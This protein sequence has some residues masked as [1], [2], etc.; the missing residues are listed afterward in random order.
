VVIESTQTLSHAFVSIF[1]EVLRIERFALLNLTGFVRIWKKYEVVEGGAFTDAG[2]DLLRADSPARGDRGLLADMHATE[3]AQ[4]RGLTSL[5]QETEQAY[6]EFFCGGNTRVAKADLHAVTKGTNDYADFYKGIKFGAMLLLALWVLWDVVVDAALRPHDSLHWRQ[7]VFPVYRAVFC[8]LFGAWCWGLNCYVWHAN[9]INY[10]YLFRLN[11]GSAVTYRDVFDHCTHWTLFVLTTFLLYYKTERG[12]LPGWVPA[13]VWP[14]VTFIPVFLR[15]LWFLRSHSRGHTNGWRLGLLQ[16][17]G[18]PFTEVTFL[19]GYIG[20]VLTSLVKV[21]ADIYYSLCWLGGGWWLSNQD[22]TPNP[23]E[24]VEVCLESSL[25]VNFIAPLLAALPLW[26]RLMQ[27]LRTYYDVRKR[28]PSLANAGK[29][30]TGMSVVIFGIFQITNSHQ[31][32]WD[33]LV[34]FYLACLIISTLYNYIWD[35]FMDWGLG[36]SEHGYLREKRMFTYRAYYYLAIVVDF[37]LRFGW[38]LTLVPSTA[39]IPL[40]RGFVEYTTPFLAAGEIARRAMWGCFRLENEHI[41]RTS[42]HKD[43]AYIPLYFESRAAEQSNMNVRRIAL[44]VIFVMAL[45]ISLGVAS[46]VVRNN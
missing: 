13:Q 43:L 39:G 12:D 22:S 20:D 38:T 17:V 35:V 7:N 11:P 8:L 30:A 15:L 44:E 9:R 1:K 31:S 5:M 45:V 37:V 4:L 23:V 10:I 27:N 21:Y 34:A 33:P 3:F 6:A 46:I 42:E 24:S 36:K 29:Y 26:W 2:G 18:A 40:S 14:I 16:V 32:T 28:F 25:F 41:K 19:A